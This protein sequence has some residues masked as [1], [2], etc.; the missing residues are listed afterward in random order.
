MNAARTLVRTPPAKTSQPQRARTVAY[1]PAPVAT[2]WRPMVQAKLR[3]GAVDDPLEREADRA[4]DAVMGGAGA[5]ALTPAI[6]PAA[7]RKC[8]AC[9]AEDEAPIQRKCAA[10]G[11][12]HGLGAATAAASAVAS[13]GRPLSPDLRAYFEPRFG[14]PLGN[15]RLHDHPGARAAADGI[16]A[17]AFTVGNDI[18]FAGGAYAPQSHA[19]RRLIAHELAHTI[20][21]APFIARQP[22]PPAP[23]FYRKRFQER[24][25][26]GTTDFEETVQVQPAPQG[27]AIVGSVNRRVIAPAVGGQAEQEVHHGQ[28]NNIRFDPD[29]NLVVPFRI[30]FQQRPTAQSN[31]SCQSPP[32]ATAAPALSA[33]QVKSISD[34]YIAAMNE[35]LNGWYSVMVEGC[36]Q[37]C[38]GKPIPIR[39]MVSEVTTN[40][41][42]TID[43]V[44]RGGRGDAGT[45]CANAF[46]PSFAVHEGGHQALGAP[47]E[48]REEDPAVLA[49]SPQWGRKERVRDDLSYM[50]DQNGY[51]RFVQFHERH[52]RFAQAFMEAVFSG[53][54]CTVS[55]KSEKPIQLDFRLDIGVG[56]G[57][58]FEIGRAHV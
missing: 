37:P 8:A 39:V 40:P 19:G 6:V 36:D 24:G 12:N 48:Y 29:C 27:M 1:R 35:G 55:L 33:A 57:A 28:V 21:Q 17:Q 42:R 32:S 44:P 25:G 47:D 30:Q 51:G 18:A 54:G 45:I 3:V 5:G 2:A 11:A 10:C 52:F 20:Q 14:R 38:A 43:I 9:E 16:G 46:T 41:D 15:V 50:N 4:A 13:G 53:Q 56:G 31:T 26:G 49:T 34:R 58:Q 7:Q 23:P 22:A